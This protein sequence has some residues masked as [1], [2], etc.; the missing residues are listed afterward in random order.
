MYR[1]ITAG[2]LLALGLLTPIQAADDKA[3]DNP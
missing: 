3:P 1:L 2:S